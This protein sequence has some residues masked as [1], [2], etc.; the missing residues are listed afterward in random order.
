MADRHRSIADGHVLRCRADGH[1][2]LMERANTG[3]AIPREPHKCARLVWADPSAPPADTVPYTAAALA[4]I[5]AG[6]PFSLDGWAGLPTGS[7]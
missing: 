4:Q 6:R 5:T 2:L 1:V 7:A 3:S